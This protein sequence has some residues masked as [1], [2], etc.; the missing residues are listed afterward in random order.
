M[1][2]EEK[3]KDFA[4]NL[5]MKKKGIST[6]ETTKIALILPFLRILGYDIENPN[7]LKA[8]YV[9][10]AGIKKREKIDLAVLI[11]DELKMLIECK[12]ANI[13]L[14]ANHINQLLRYFSVSNVKISVLTNGVI[15][16]F[17]TDFENPGKMDE[18]PFLEVDL[19]NLTGKKIESLLLFTKDNF[20]DEKIL[21]HVEE[22]KYRQDIHQTLLKEIHYPSDEL[23]RLIA[24]KVYSSPLTKSRKKYFQKIIKEE[25][26]DVFENNY[27]L[28]TSKIITTEEEILGFNIVRA[29]VSE[30]VDPNR[31][32]M[33]DRQ[34]Y[35]PILF[36]NNH[37]YTICRLHFNDLDNIAIG[38]FDSLSKDKDGSRI[39][40]KIAIDKIEDIYNYKEK[41]LG[42][43]A[44]YKKIK[45]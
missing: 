30:I 16:W 35:C 14:N 45:D 10:D 3:L 27:S 11:D 21:E 28:E 12:P 44:H 42:T 31:I 18:T 25:L 13:N 8:E 34:S 38:F 9:A 19:R 6:E 22:L 32:V 37:N 7:E 17:F 15:Y 23:I 29:I 20:S 40:E 4:K 39:E 41:L 43:V 2:F 24:K 26:L 36:D 5:P 33:R 1:T